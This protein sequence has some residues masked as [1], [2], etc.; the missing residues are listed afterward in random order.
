MSQLLPVDT[1]IIVTVGPLIDDTDFKTQET[2]IAYNASGMSIDLIEN[3]GTAA[4]KTDLTLTTSGTSD[5][6]HLGNSVYSLEITAAQNNTEGTLEIQ[7]FV[8][9]VLPFRSPTYT[10][11][12][13]AVYNS[14]VLGSDNLQVD[15]L[16]IEGADA[17]DTI[18][19]QA[20]LAATD[21]DAATG[22]E[23]GNLN[24]FN[25]ASDDVAVV[26][27][28]ATTTANTDMITAA[29]VN[30][31]ADLALSDY[32]PPTNTEMIARTIVAANYFDPAADTVG[33]VTNVAA[34]TGHTAQT[35]DHTATL[36]G[37][38]DITAAD[39]WTTGSRE[40]STPSSYMADVSGLATTSAL[41]T[42]DTVAD[43]V[44]VDT[45]E[46]QTWFTNM[47]E[48]DG[49]DFRFVTNALEQA[50]S[51]GGGGDA[52]A[53]NQTQLLAD[54]AAVLARGN[55]AWVTGGGGAGAVT[56][57]YTLTDSATSDPLDDVLVEVFTEVGMSNRTASLRTDAFGV[58]TFALDAG[59]YYLKRSKGG[60][61]FTNPDSQVVAE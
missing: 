18:N 38:N 26:T 1:A 23:V 57:V 34:L 54:V 48:A 10:V 58:A 29:S 17:T 49:A 20:D 61:T 12:P 43:T 28:V 24:N 51:G 9:G 13:V 16:Q 39:V 7:G 32:D 52:T 44:L 19:A 21:Y 31:Q 11:V 45:N 14:L 47:I 55:A 41:A 27:L 42:L 22:T 40:L 25:P 8:T 15:T 46:L 56:F 5:W 60:Y 36:A 2:G 35:A 3:S 30:A 4:T 37:L 33:T 50:P 6:V 53:A 59:T